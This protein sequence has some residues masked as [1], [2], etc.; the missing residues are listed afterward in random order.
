MF[1]SAP[2]RLPS[3]P[4]DPA[5]SW[6]SPLGRISYDL[7]QHTACSTHTISMCTH[8]LACQIA[9][10]PPGELRWSRFFFFQSEHRLNSATVF[11]CDIPRPNMMHLKWKGGWSYVEKKKHPFKGYCCY[12]GCV[13]TLRRRFPSTVWVWYPRTKVVAQGEVWCRTLQRQ[14]GDVDVMWQLS[15]VLSAQFSP[16]SSLFVLYGNK[17]NAY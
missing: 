3:L 15:C 12:F 4:R 8:S 9:M 11:I 1:L 13:S 6:A 2:Q 17:Y 10:P 14:R 5:P 16:L 7:Q